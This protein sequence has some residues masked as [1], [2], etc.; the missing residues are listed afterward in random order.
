MPRPHEGWAGAL[1]KAG[2]R[3]RRE[4]ALL[5]GR[6]RLR[7]MSTP[8]AS[9][10]VRQAE[11]VSRTFGWERGEPIDRYYIAGFLAAHAADITGHVLEVGDD[12]Y[13]RRFG[14]AVGANDVLDIDPAN[15]RAT[16]VDDLQTGA[17]MPSGAFDCVVLVQTLPFVFDV[18]GA[19]SQVHR[20]LATG[21]VVLAT[22][23]GVSQ[24][25]H[26]GGHDYW[27]FTEA[28]A[29]R[30]FGEAFGDDG[31]TVEVQGNLTSTCAF[32]QGRAA[33]ELTREQ[34]DAYDDDYPLLIG[35]R[36]VKSG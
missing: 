1:A 36:A 21:G 26:S 23:P 13:T 5:P 20:V 16:I 34:L 7:R 6:G 18:R 14:R 12:R 15:R 3:A 31:V 9:W 29:R 4:V 33:E 8:P 30:V 25:C 27:R 10:D 32:L 19:I 17:R 2:S 11:P 24:R 28:A 22:V 35:V